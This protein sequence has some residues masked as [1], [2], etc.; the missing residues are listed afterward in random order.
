MSR[1]DD[2]FA[3]A[4]RLI[5]GG[6]NSPVRSFQKVGRNPIYFSHAEGAYLWD[7]D[8]KR[9]IDF[10]LGFGPHL[11]GHCPPTVVSALRDQAGKAA[12]FGANHEKEVLL[13]E[14]L[15]KAY[16]FLG[17]V[18]LVNSGTEAVMTAVRI[19]RGFT[20]RDKIIQFEGCYH[21]HSD[22]LLTKAGSGVAELSEA[23][24]HGVPRSIVQETITARYDDLAG[25][26]KV[27]EKYSGQIAAVLLEPIPANHGLWV[28]PRELLQAIG[29]LAQK[30][31]A[32]VIFD[33]VISGFRVGI[34]GASGY[35]D[36]RPDLVTLGKIVGGGLPLAAI[37]GRS[38]VM[39]VLAPVGPVYQAG[40][41]SGNPM[42]AAAGCAVMEAVFA[43][44]P[45][46]LLE[47][48]TAYFAER[49]RALFADD[50]TFR[51]RTFGSLFWIHF[52][53]DA[54]VFPPPVGQESQMK[55]RTLFHNAL[56]SGV[57]F[58]PSPYE[59]GFLS[60]AHT[61]EIIDDVVERLR[62]CIP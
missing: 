44:P 12:T 52:E 41:L 3:R 28:P 33:E 8:G 31:G 20:G 18:R 40:T 4:L 58:A 5:P 45:Y 13:A 50:A 36:L 7:V 10:C 11:L 2:L 59:V 53:D 34:S 6:V 14:W 57:Y 56:E 23:A 46:A 24:S 62:V 51:I 55:Y 19:A 30:H 42:A 29:S 26:S 49:L 16:P 61:E 9:Y 17:K 35:F 32:L 21:G 25:L 37:V 48:R 15:I 39:D 38:D 27:F 1:S 22:G 60:A 43:D 54:A 47:K